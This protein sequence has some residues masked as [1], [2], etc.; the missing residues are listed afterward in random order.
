MIA[1]GVVGL[2]LAVRITICAV[3]SY[4]EVEA[5][6]SMGAVSVGKGLMFR[7]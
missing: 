7:V 1:V 4:G 3:E 6:V 5:V 2:W